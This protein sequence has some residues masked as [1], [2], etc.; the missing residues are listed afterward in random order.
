MIDRRSFLSSA[1]LAGFGMRSG[2]FAQLQSLPSRLPDRALFD[3]NQ[4][5]YWKELRKQFLIPADENT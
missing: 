2:L 1:L 5:A 4:D 3:A